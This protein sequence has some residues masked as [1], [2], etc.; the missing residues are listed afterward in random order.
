[1]RNRWR[2]GGLGRDPVAMSLS[3]LREWCVMKTRLKQ[4]F[5]PE[6]WPFNRGMLFD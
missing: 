6:E 2:E 5:A 1:M 4:E 3:R